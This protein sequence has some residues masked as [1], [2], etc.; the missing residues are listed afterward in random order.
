MSEPKRKYGGYLIAEGPQFDIIAAINNNGNSPFMDYYMGLKE[1]VEKKLKQ[2]SKKHKSVRDYKT[3]N[4]Y[5][6]KFKNTGPWNNRT[7][8]NSLEDDFWEFKNV[9]SGLRVPFY[10]DESNRRVI[11]LTHYFEKKYQKTRQSDIKRMQQIR[12]EFQEYRRRIENE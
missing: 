12:S 11:I 6:G 2:G 3:L 4:Y 5:F 10:Y 9:D 8:I 1:T 7:Q